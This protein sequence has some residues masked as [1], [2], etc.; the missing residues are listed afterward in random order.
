MMGVQ[1]DLG[2]VTPSRAAIY[3]QATELQALARLAVEFTVPGP[4]ADVP[5]ALRQ[6]ARMREVLG[7][8]DS[9]AEL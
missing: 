2:P 3:A 4:G 5:R 6:I 8:D 9:E 7:L 1:A